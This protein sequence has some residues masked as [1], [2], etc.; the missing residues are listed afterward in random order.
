MMA[1]VNRVFT[2]DYNYH[3]PTYRY[4][5]SVH[6]SSMVEIKTGEM[7]ESITI[8]ELHERMS[9]RQLQESGKEYG[10]RTGEN[11]NVRVL[12]YNPDTHIIY[13]TDFLF[14]I[15]HATSKSQWEIVDQYDNKLIVTGDHSVM[16]Y[17][18]DQL[19]E[20]KPQDIISSDLLIGINSTS[21]LSNIKTIRQLDDF[22][23]EPVYDIN[24]SGDHPYFFANRILAHNTD[25][26]YFSAYDIMRDQIER[27]ELTWTKE[28]VAEL[29]DHVCE[30]V[31][32]SFTDFMKTAFHC[33]ADYARPI[34]AGREI[35][36][37]SGL[38]ITK[39]R[40]AIMVY[41]NEGVREDV[42]GRPGKVKA[43][44]LDL[45]RSDTPVFIQNFLKEILEK[46][47]LGSD[48]RA[49]LDRIVEYRDEFR[50]LPAWRKGTPKAVNKLSWY[51]EQIEKG[52][53]VSVPGHVRASLNWNSL[54]SANG[55]KYSMEIV[56]GMKVI[57]CKMR[58]NP[59]GYTSV[60]YPTDEPRIPDWFKELPFDESLMELAILDKKLENLIGELGYDIA[61]TNSSNTFDTLFEF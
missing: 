52:K 15:K 14:T 42:N 3:G 47:L 11:E 26:C 53:R 50:D 7:L 55:D 58:D 23:N 28:S 22:D 39:K 4:G 35:V 34:A 32:G 6:G 40:Y 25:S 21:R 60:A 19:M 18:D 54:R 44:G 45:R 17:R 37:T 27:G 9:Y 41:D 33:P 1:E 48:E 12:S 57:V 51:R 49:I 59:L 13:Y 2:G 24:V 5:D 10:Y 29:Y 31:N 56:D 43:M 30:Q 61:Q 16:V 46:V 8:A 20:M 38:F 36:G